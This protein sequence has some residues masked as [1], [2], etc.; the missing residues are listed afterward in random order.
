ML[1]VLVWDPFVLLCRSKNLSPSLAPTD[2]Q[3]KGLQQAERCCFFLTAS[4]CFSTCCSLTCWCPSWGNSTTRWMLDPQ[5]VSTRTSWTSNINRLC[6]VIEAYRVCSFVCSRSRLP[7]T[8][9]THE[10][11]DKPTCRQKAWLTSPL[12]VCFWGLQPGLLICATTIT[13]SASL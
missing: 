13:F 10:G 1:T 11:V 7:V 8:L 2:W 6:E 3:H 4:C 12:W 9:Y 5:N